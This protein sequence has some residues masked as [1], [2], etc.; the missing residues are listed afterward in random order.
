MA[1]TAALEALL[2]KQLLE[3]SHAE[4]MQQECNAAFGA[5]GDNATWQGW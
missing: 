2:L 3:S 1:C 4:Q 5:A